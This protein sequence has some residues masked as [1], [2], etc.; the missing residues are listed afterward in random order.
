MT[1]LN[2]S[3]TYD[4]FCDEDKIYYP[5]VGYVYRESARYIPISIRKA[6][7]LERTNSYFCRSNFVK[8]AKFNNNT[9]IKELEQLEENLLNAE[10]AKKELEESSKSD[11]K[12]LNEINEK[13]K[14]FEEKLHLSKEIISNINNQI[15]DINN[16]TV[17]QRKI[18][19]AS[20]QNDYDIAI[21]KYTD[22][23]ND[24]DSI[25]IPDRPV[26]N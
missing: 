24:L 3:M 19:T 20:E 16:E 26:E 13:I 15:L 8:L 12:E 18:R 2:Q 5:G 1:E 11:L 25:V 4:N 17:E 23:K 21:K 10:I 6:L 22:I 7:E 14:I 9:E